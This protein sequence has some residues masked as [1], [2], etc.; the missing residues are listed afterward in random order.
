[1]Y[2]FYRSFHSSVYRENISISDFDKKKEVNDYYY[3]NLL[4]EDKNAKILDLG[5]GDGNFVYYL[6]NQGYKNAMGVDISL[7]QIEYGK[8]IGVSN[9]Y[10]YAS[11][12]FL[13][14]EKSNYSC[15]IVKDVFEH[16]TK[17][18]AYDMLELIYM[19]LKKGGTCLIQ[20][21]NAQGL[22]YTTYFYGDY[23][24]DVV[25]THQSMKQ[26]FL[27]IGFQKILFY[28]VNPYPGS[29]LGKIRALL[30]RL[31]VLE[32]KFWK[33]V[34]TGSSEGVFTSNIIALGIK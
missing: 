27:S 20:V 4:P 5:C 33:I 8:K 1:M 9:I 16:F 21:P 7:E 26:L 15:V 19:S 14:N 34:E 11:M 23:T 13:K 25:F 17:Q 22:F 6:H 32:M 10:H 18:E 31:K 24:H 12:D 28:P 30:W 2:D 3:Y 29:F